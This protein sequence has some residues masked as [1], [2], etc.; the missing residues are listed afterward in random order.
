MRRRRWIIALAA[1][2]I[3]A[4]GVLAFVFLVSCPNPSNSQSAPIGRRENGP[5]FGHDESRPIGQTH[6][7]KSR[8]ELIS[9]LGQPTREGPWPIGNPPLSITDKFKCMRT[10]EWDWDSGKFLASVHLVDGQWVCFDS[11]WVPN[12][13]VID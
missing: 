6:V 3:V 8:D 10:L 2:A 5:Q 1:L 4:A 7:G 9:E 12:G 11:Y 13:W